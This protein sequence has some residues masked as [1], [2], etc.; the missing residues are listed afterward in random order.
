MRLEDEKDWSESSADDSSSYN[1]EFTSSSDD[2]EGEDFTFS[3][4]HE[5]FED[6]MEKWI[7]RAVMKRY[8]DHLELVMHEDLPEEGELCTFEGVDAITKSRQQ[9]CIKRHKYALIDLYGA[10]TGEN[11]YGIKNWIK[12]SK[13]E[14]GS[15]ER[16]QYPYGRMHEVMTKMIKHYRGQVTTGY[17]SLLRDLNDIT[18]K[19]GKHPDLV[20]N[21]M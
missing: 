11:T 7:I 2:S 17:K 10:C 13:G 20:F 1:S 19:E 21:Q 5:D 8:H 14:L 15:N 12:R 3:G 6:F 18:T 4:N 9:K 16:R